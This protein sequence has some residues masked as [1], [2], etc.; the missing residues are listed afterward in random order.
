MDTEPL[1]L[2]AATAT[3]A[4]TLADAIISVMFARDVIRIISVGAG[5]LNQA[6]KAVAIINA[7]MEADRQTKRIA[8][9]PSFR[10]FDVGG[11]TLTGIT[12]EL[13]EHRG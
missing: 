9:S 2:R 8:F 5:A 4:P 3:P 12:L 11:E 1:T 13:M 7:R 6:V 10:D